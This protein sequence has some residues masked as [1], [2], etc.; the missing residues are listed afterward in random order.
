MAIITGRTIEVTGESM[1]PKQLAM[2]FYLERPNMRGS[3]IFTT[4]PAKVVPL[5]TGDWSVNLAETTLMQ[6]DA[7]YRLRL[8]WLA[9]G[10]TYRDFPDWKIRVPVGGGNFGELTTGAFDTNLVYCSPN[11]VDNTINTGFQLNT[12]TGDLFQR[13]N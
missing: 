10:A 7:W 3:E 1:Y 2:E 4:E 9:T 12:L 13:R 11:A 6:F 8:I 5:S